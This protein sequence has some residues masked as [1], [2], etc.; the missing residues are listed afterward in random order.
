L[1][2]RLSEPWISTVKQ[3][4]PSIKQHPSNTHVTKGEVSSLQYMDYDFIYDV[5]V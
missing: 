4:Y 3:F 1:S 5:I 2:Y